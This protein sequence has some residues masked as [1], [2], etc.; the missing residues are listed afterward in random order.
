MLVGVGKAVA[1][2][3]APLMGPLSQFLCAGRDGKWQGSIRDGSI[4]LANETDS[5]ARASMVKSW[6][7]WATRSLVADS[8]A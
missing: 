6:G 1:A 8:S 3:G 2:P 5:A 4:I 7:A